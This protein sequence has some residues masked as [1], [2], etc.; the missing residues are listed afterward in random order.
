MKQN[1]IILINRLNETLKDLVGESIASKYLNDVNVADAQAWI[2]PQRWKFLLE[3]LG[4]WNSVVESAYNKMINSENK[5]SF[6]E[7]ELKHLGQPLKGVYFNNDNGVPTFLKYSQAVL[8]PSLIKNNGLETLYNK[9]IKDSEGNILSYEE[10]IHELITKDGI[11]VGSLTPVESHDQFGNVKN[12]NEF[13]LNNKIILSNQ[14][15]KLQQDLPTKNLHDTQIG[16]Q[17]QK[18]IFQGLVYNLNETFNVD[19]K[20]IKGSEYLISY[21]SLSIKIH[22]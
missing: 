22:L 5:E 19:G 18:I 20:N 21:V 6:N 15:W 9:M 7:E 2:T 11:K 14:Y 16:S 17:I 12:A 3:G 4:K 1:K 10:Q 13:D 8:W